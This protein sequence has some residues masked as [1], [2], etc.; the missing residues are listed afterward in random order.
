MHPRLAA[1]AVALGLLSLAVASL[2]ASLAVSR[3][4]AAGPL[5]VRRSEPASARGVA[6][7]YARLPLAFEPNRGQAADGTV[8]IARGRGYA[9]EADASHVR[10]AVQRQPDRSQ[11]AIE[12]EIVDGHREAR[13]T[14][15]ERLP[16]RS[17]YFLGDRRAEPIRD[18]PHFGRM[19]V[20]EVYPD[21]DLV[22]YGRQDQLEYDFVVAPG[23][24]PGRI[25]L[26]FSGQD[27]LDIDPSGALVLHAGDR[28][29]R[30]PRP[31]VYQLPDRTP[32]DGRFVMR[33]DGTVGFD[34]PA[35]DHQRPLVIDPT[36]VFGT[37]LGG[38]GDDVARG[39]AVD[40]AG[41]VY[42]SGT[43]ASSNFPLAVPIQPTYGGQGDVFVTKMNAAGTAI[44]YS[45]FLGGSGADE[46]HGIAVDAAGAAYVT[47]QASPGFPVS[48]PLTTGCG[49]RDAFITKLTPT[50]GAL[51]YSLC[52]GTGGTEYGNG[53]AVD[54][55]QQAY[56]TGLYNGGDV[57]AA[58]LN[59]SGTAWIYFQTYTGNSLDEGLGIGVNA[60]GFACVTGTTWSSTF[61]VLNARQPTAGGFI[62]AFTMKLGPTGTVVYATYLG[63]PFL[64]SGNGAAAD[65]AG[66]CY[67]T[68]TTTGNFP[69]QNPAIPVARGYDGF[70]TAYNSTGSAY[71][72]STYLGGSASDA[73]FA[74]AATPTGEVHVTGE[75]SS[76]DFPAINTPQPELK[77]IGAVHRSVDRGQ[78]V[79]R[80]SLQGPSVQAL[81]ASPV[82]PQVVYA[83]TSNG[84]YR[85][86][87]GGTS[88]ARVDAG[89]AN[90]DVVALAVNP[91][92]PCTIYGGVETYS[93]T[94]NTNA[95]A[96]ISPDC[97][98]TWGYQ[99][100]T[101]IG[102]V[103]RSFAVAATTPATLY[104][105][106][107]SNNAG[108]AGQESHGVG[109][110]TATGRETIFFP[111][112]YFFTVAVDAV[113]PCIAYSGEWGGAV[114]V[115]TSCT[116]WNWSTL[117]TVTGNVLA[118]AAHPTLG[119]NVL[120]GT[121]AGRIVRRAD[122]ASPWVTVAAVAGSISAIAY[123]PGNPSL[124][125][126]AG[127]AGVLL[128]SL[129]GGQTWAVVSSVGP[130]IAALATNPQPDTV[131]AGTLVNT[132]AFY[133]RFSTTGALLDAMW[134]GGYGADSGGAIALEASGAPTIAGS[135][136]STS[137]P[138]TAGAFA[139]AS[140][141]GV[142]AFVARLSLAAPCTYAIS[143]SPVYARAQGRTVTVSVSASRGDCPWTATT[144]VPW[145]GVGAGSPGTGSGSVTLTV[146]AN[147]GAARRGIV[148]VAGHP[149]TVAQDP[150]P[151]PQD[152][153]LSFP[154]YGL[155]TV[156]G[157]TWQQLHG[158]SP[159]ALVN[160]DLD[161]NQSDDLIVDFGPGVGLWAWMN[162]A[163]WVWL[164][165]LSPSQ[166]AAADIDGNGVDDLVVDFPGYGV[167]VRF[168]NGGWFRL[169]AADVTVL[170]AARMTGS[171]GEQLVMNFPG[172]GVWVYTHGAGWRNLHPAN[173]RAIV[174][175]DL[176]GNYQDDLVIEFSGGQGIWAYRNDATWALVHGAASTH[177]VAANSDG[178]SLGDLIVDFGPAGIWL[179][180]NSS[181]WMPLHGRSAEGIVAGDLDGNGIDEVIIDFG[182]AGL[183]R[184]QSGN[185]ALV[186]G[187]S[188]G[189][190]AVGGWH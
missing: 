141:G 97:G 37:Y 187:L 100:A 57:F 53:I 101:P 27:A 58:K 183:W 188:P 152:L 161:G 54:A 25:A 126:A 160:G 135:T 56:A 79:G 88:W 95:A 105:T 76:A 31:V 108:G 12:M 184:Y 93:S 165:G 98:A 120:V 60:G 137:F 34:I 24:E 62:D 132:D 159:R 146:Q 18:V 8:A 80:T 104:W 91:A 150:A 174:A 116:T 21:I 128:R 153:A 123:S 149:F 140:S 32:V 90:T 74:I 186:H 63:G 133:A 10:L 9:L 180:R 82:D 42:V 109:R 5:A 173:A 182:A 92:A 61:P 75:T 73:G 162:H 142:D 44:V 86:T 163:T 48:G 77:D 46:G 33:G 136:R 107:I 39:V 41:S 102:R 147:G 3:G 19:I 167:W 38:A 6:V 30:Q 81:A 170:A 179:W 84:I 65:D 156:G 124:V 148:T 125:Y 144:A 13:T 43:T 175:S 189:A 138:T 119:G 99:T 185:W 122:A 171:G 177:L 23:A 131:Y 94:V 117:T 69:L 178:D 87:N 169:H 111:G 134:L 66:N 113:N 16:G 59:A 181:T 51:A 71:L 26:R 130:A 96:V 40:A 118:I 28:E 4:P 164:H 115:N 11:R 49:G 158:R 166:M 29:L 52:A 145:I 143:P 45:T 127:S 68:G 151:R 129:D 7:S 176:D 20:H 36:L 172:Y 47:G 121:S 55:A 190:M 22:Y 83:G 103:V 157:S 78:T 14:F 70:V 106:L 110:T 17:H 50:G 2:V 35:W 139:P 154:V 85:T 15:E 114:S 64:D 89:L 155:W 67:V 168:N 1:P 72:Y 112:R